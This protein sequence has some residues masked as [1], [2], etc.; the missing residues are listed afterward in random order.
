[1]ADLQ[2]AVRATAVEDATAGRVPQKYARLRQ[3][4]Q[5]SVRA[6]ADTL[7]G[8]F[9]I[10]APLR[11]W[12]ASPFRWKRSSPQKSI[13]KRF[14]TGAMSFGSISREAH[15]TL[16]IA[17]NR[18]GGQAR[19]PAKAA[20]KL[21]ASSSDAQRRLACA[22]RSSRSRR[23]ASASPPSI[24]S[25]RTMMQIKMAQGAKP[26]E[27]GQ[28]PGHKV[29]KPTSPRFATQRRA[30]VS[31]RP[32]PTMTFTRSKISPSSF[33]DLKNVNPARATSQ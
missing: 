31:F 15:T 18:I 33:F 23:V 9:R 19:T 1:M 7:R 32:R 17:M 21:T 3:G 11:K 4:H 16:A 25:T 13:V 6:A 8:L 10:Q 24:W 20:R 30:S 22:R 28:L 26:G 14:A 29:D 2:H 5:R 12:A 27:G